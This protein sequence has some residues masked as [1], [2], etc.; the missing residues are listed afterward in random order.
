MS[1]KRYVRKAVIPA[2]G[3]GTRLLPVTKAVPK[4]LLPIVNKPSIQYIVEE[5]LL[6]G[7]EHIIFVISADKES[8][9]D[10]FDI[11][12]NLECFLE[13]LGKK[14]LLKDIKKISRTIEIIS[15]RQKEPLGLGHAVLTAETAVG[16][17]PFA[18]LLPDDLVDSQIPC[19]SQLLGIFDKENS[20]VIALERVPKN[21]T[22]N[23]GIIEGRKK[24]GRIWNITALIEKP[25]PE[26]APSALAVIG[27]YILPPEIFGILKRTKPGSGGEIQLT[28]ALSKLAGMGKLLGVEFSGKRYDIGNP[29]GLIIANVAYGIK[30]KNIS[31]IIKKEFARRFRT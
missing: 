3:L 4:E 6:S 11:D 25:A 26:E 15:V 13:K 29:E 23:Y 24:N 27:R 7:I 12:G 5:A 21:K 30:H 8:I 9:L 1:R 16:D 28:D 2:A 20:G 19:L 18:V 10:Y 14:N 22:T 17:E 31:S